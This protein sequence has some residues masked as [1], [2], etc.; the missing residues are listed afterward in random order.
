[1]V[2]Y[3]AFKQGLVC[4]G[5]RFHEGMNITEK[6]D[7]VQNGFHGA[8]NP[9]DCFAYYPPSY[10]NG[11]VYYMCEALGDIDE[12]ERDSKVSCT[13]LN[14]VRKLTYYDMAACALIYMKKHPE[15]KLVELSGNTVCVQ[16]NMAQVSEAG[17][18]LARGI[19]PMAKGV[20]GAS[21]GFAATDRKD[22]VMQ[23]RIGM[24][25]G[26][27]ILPGRYY[28][29]REGELHEVQGTGQAARR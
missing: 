2:I 12:D 19:K 15:R 23:I 6:A 20:M 5:Y 26:I 25:D 4:R 17:I 11:D 28:E 22:R 14:I 9:L 21:L 10:G 13:H 16:Y 8:E 27:H 1:M 3:K 7:C 29:Y 24:V 18:A